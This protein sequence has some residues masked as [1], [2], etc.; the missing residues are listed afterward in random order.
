MLCVGPRARP[1]DDSSVTMTVPPEL[2]RFVI[3]HRND[4]TLSIYVEATDP[5]ARRSWPALLRRQL[6][7]A[8]AHLDSAS[9][10]ERDDFD[11]CAK[12][13]GERLPTAQSLPADS[14]WAGF[15]VA[16]D[17]L[18]LTIPTG[19]T[20]SARWGV[21][22]DIVPYLRVKDEEAALV[23]RLDRRRALVSRLDRGAPKLIAEYTAEAG[24]RERR[25]QE[26][27]RRPRGRPQQNSAERPRMPRPRRQDA[28]EQ[29][30]EALAR[31]LPSLAERE[32]PI[33]VGTAPRLEAL[34]ALRLPQP[35]TRRVAFSPCLRNADS[36]SARCAI[37]HE[38]HSLLGRRQLQR[39]ASLLDDARQSS[40]VAVG[41]ETVASAAAHGAIAELIVSDH[42]WRQRP[43]EI[44]RIVRRAVADRAS[45][46]WADPLEAGGGVIARLHFSVPEIGW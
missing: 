42:A 46:S 24:G 28:V 41:F 15:C 2:I 29:M 20:T 38:M 17:I 32:L 13:L 45:V 37:R 4:L 39:V 30:Q 1:S 22:P 31:D 10:E 3:D 11:Q 23:V 44:E 26:N 14:A 16:D 18:V 27:G 35:L 5:A 7:E 9:K 34:F 6:S 21:G 40:R 43:L 36:T 8:R 19:V 25:A 12:H 33:V